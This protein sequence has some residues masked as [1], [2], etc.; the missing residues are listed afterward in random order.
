MP[1]EQIGL[2]VQKILAERLADLERQVSSEALPGEDRAGWETYAAECIAPSKGSITDFAAFAV[3]WPG[4]E[5]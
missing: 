3:V 1:L 2:T 4:L 5:R